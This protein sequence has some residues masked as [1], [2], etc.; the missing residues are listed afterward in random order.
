MILNTL[1]TIARRNV[2]RQ[3]L[4]VTVIVLIGSAFVVG[5]RTRALSTQ[6]LRLMSR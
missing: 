2:V 1:N 4:I 5:C 3:L 6:F